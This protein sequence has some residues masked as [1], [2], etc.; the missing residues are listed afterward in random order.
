MTAPPSEVHLSPTIDEPLEREAEALG[1]YLLGSVPSPE[2]IERY[3]RGSRVLFP[4]SPDAT[5]RE[6][7]VVAYYHARA[8]YGKI[9]SE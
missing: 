1:R 2:E 7:A 4:G 9:L 5:S 3:V 6:A 8:R